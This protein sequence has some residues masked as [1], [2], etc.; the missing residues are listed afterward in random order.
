LRKKA[1]SSDW[2]HRGGGLLNYIA[3]DFCNQDAC[4]AI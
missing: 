3:F 2:I 4:E 1:R